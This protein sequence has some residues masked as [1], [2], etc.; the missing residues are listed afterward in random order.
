MMTLVAGTV[1]RE[2]GASS[3]FR[4]DSDVDVFF[5]LSIEIVISRVDFVRSSNRAVS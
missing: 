2:Y 1:A 3:M 4:I 5:S